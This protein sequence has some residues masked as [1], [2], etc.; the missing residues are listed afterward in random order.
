M[1]ALLVV[2][3]GAVIWRLFGTSPS[4]TDE[5]ARTLLAWTVMCGACLALREQGH[6]AITA[7]TDRF[8]GRLRLINATL[9]DVVVLAFLLFLAWAGVQY[10]QL[11]AQSGVL[12]PGLGISPNWGRA[13]IVAGAGVMAVFTVLQLGER[14]M[15]I[16]RCGNDTQ[17]CVATQ[18]IDGERYEPNGGI[19]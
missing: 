8:R 15:E 5:L 11:G 13:S 17:V 4:G 6:L 10:V 2:V 14:V 9:V 19:D 16:C 18:T 12:T 1:I 7:V 3:A